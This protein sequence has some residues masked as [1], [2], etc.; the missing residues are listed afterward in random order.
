MSIMLMELF[1]SE[2][3]SLPRAGLG[4]RNGAFASVSRVA[5]VSFLLLAFHADGVGGSIAALNSGMGGLFVM[6]SRLRSGNWDGF[7]WGGDRFEDF[8]LRCF[9]R[10]L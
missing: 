3:P 6:R 9:A 5:E 4:G 2:G 10:Y 1:L 8:A 7:A